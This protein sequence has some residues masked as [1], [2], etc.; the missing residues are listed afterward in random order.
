MSLQSNPDTQTLLLLLL[1]LPEPHAEYFTLCLSQLWSITR[2]HQSLM[3]KYPGDFEPR[4][5][6]TC[7]FSPVGVAGALQGWDKSTSL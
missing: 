4:P 3:G 6:G 1:L 2:A 5:F 7:L